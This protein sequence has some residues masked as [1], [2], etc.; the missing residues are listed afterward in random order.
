MW[1]AT[2]D[3]GDSGS[4]LTARTR[5]TQLDSPC[6]ASTQWWRAGRRLCDGSPWWIVMATRWTVASGAVLR[7]G[8][9]WGLDGTDG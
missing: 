3:G 9:S 2:V 6:R 1:R 4:V 5:K 7:D 8:G